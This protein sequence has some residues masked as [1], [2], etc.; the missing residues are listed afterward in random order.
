MDKTPRA[1]AKLDSAFSAGRLEKEPG[2][3]YTWSRTTTYSTTMDSVSLQ[4]KSTVKVV[5][6]APFLDGSD[7]QSVS[8]A[9]LDSFK[10]IGFVYLINHGLPQNKIDSMFFWVSPNHN[11]CIPTLWL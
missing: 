2:N 3:R 5:D 7:R 10:T 6:F 8:N 1:L 9:I 11:D 4:N